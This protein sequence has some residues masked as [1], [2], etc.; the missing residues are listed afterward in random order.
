MAEPRKSRWRS[1][2][3]KGRSKAGRGFETPQARRVRRQAFQAALD[4]ADA[5]LAHREA[6]DEPAREVAA[7]DAVTGKRDWP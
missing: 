7:F 2:A 4:A 5:F 3:S 6:Y 1:K